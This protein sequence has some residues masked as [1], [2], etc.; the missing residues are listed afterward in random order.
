MKAKTLVSTNGL[1]RDEW[2]KYRRLGIGGSDIAAIAGVSPFGNP[3]SVFLDKIGG[4]QD[5]EETEAMYW[6][7][8]LESVVADE[9][10]R[11]HPEVRMQRV[12]AILM[13]PEYHWA[14]ANLDRRI[15]F[16]DRGWGVLEIKT[17]NPLFAG[18]WM[19]E[20]G[21]D[22]IPDEYVCQ[23]QWYMGITGYRYAV[24]ACLIGGSRFIERFIEFDQ[25]M[26]EHLLK[27]GGD[28]WVMVR[29]RE[30]PALDGSKHSEDL[31]RY[32]YP[33]GHPQSVLLDEVLEAEDREILS[34]RINGYRF[35]KEQRDKYQGFMD[36]HENHIKSVM[37]DNSVA[38]F[39]ERYQLKWQTQQSSWLDAKAIKED[40]PDVYAK[41]IRGKE[42]RKFY[43]TEKQPKKKEK[44]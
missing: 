44:K 16:P 7:N 21:E 3:V 31:L 10:K 9:F 15:H 41:Y 12:N 1:S 28:F 32:L 6:G 5:K 17:T 24:I 13:H 35:A 25:E 23:V 38:F 2:L 34:E 37:G 39:G 22:A 29:S 11:R 40:M 43:L 42:Y 4:G 36:E 14:L 19:D 18:K 33:K 26:F 27:I 20:A 8:V 30:M